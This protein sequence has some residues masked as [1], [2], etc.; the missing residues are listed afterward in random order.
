MAGAT[1]DRTPTGVVKA[2]WAAFRSGDVQKAFGHW[3]SDAVWR[4]TGRHPRA[5]DYTPNDYAQMLAAFS[6]EFPEYSGEFLNARNLGE[7]A[8]FDVRSRGGPAPGE[9]QGIIIYRVRDGLIVEGW[10]VPANHGGHYPF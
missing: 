1:I 6:G 9:S 2:F 3:S 4:L 10:A 5:G 8:I 7:L